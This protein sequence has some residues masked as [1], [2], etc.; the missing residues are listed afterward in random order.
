MAHLAS[1]NRRLE[2]SRLCPISGAQAR[3]VWFASL[4]QDTHAPAGANSG[5]HRPAFGRRHLWCWFAS[6]VHGAAL[7]GRLAPGPPLRRLAQQMHGYAAH[8]RS[9]AFLTFY[10]SAAGCPPAAARSWP[11]MGFF[12]FS[13]RRMQSVG[14]ERSPSAHRIDAHEDQRGH[15]ASGRGGSRPPRLAS[16]RL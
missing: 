12:M 8:E 11:A 2:V 4:C 5:P 6:R 9:L 13:R 14:P 1:T 15:F 3:L 16:T 10:G 7:L